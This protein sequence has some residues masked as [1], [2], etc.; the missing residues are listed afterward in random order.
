MT[1][2]LYPNLP[3]FM[4]DDEEAIL[5]GYKVALSKG[6]IN[7]TIACGDSNKALDMLHQ[8]PASLV[9]LDLTMPYVSGEELL[10]KI[11]S[12]YPGI[13]VIIVTGNDDINTAIKCIKAGASD[14][15]TKPVSRERLLRTVQQTL[16]IRELQIENEA[17]RK[18]IL[19]EELINTEA[20]SKIITANHTMISIIR[21]IA[22][23][24]ATPYPVLL[25]GETGVGKEVIAQAIHKA[26]ARTG[27]FVPVNI[28]GLDDN[29]LADTL[30]GH[31][32]GAF[33][34]AETARAG[35]IEE[36]QGGTLFL[37]E[38]GD[39]SITSQV[40]LLRL[41]QEHEY[42]PLGEDRPRKSDARIIVATNADLTELQETGKFRPDL[43]FRLH[44]HH[45]HIPPL[46][47]RLDD[48]PI[49][50]DHFLTVSADT[51]GKK[52]PTPPPEL[53]AL[54]ATYHFPGNVRELASMITDAVSRHKSKMLSMETFNSYIAPRRTKL[55]SGKA[56]E[57]NNSPES[58]NGLI[59]GQTLPPLK[60]AKR[61]FIEEAIKRSNGNMTL[62]AK[63]L[64]TTRQA[65]SW[66][67]KKDK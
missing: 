3:I 31:K 18:E 58:R 38:I 26:S 20:F 48:L 46:R 1:N 41:L 14:Y 21:Y 17:L 40:K 52:K 66:H 25:S 44:T 43:F 6:G 50:V 67:T 56:T 42:L 15:L 39:L 16:S 19:A 13:P 55:S 11:T 28:A 34:S 59:F 36:A 51:L 65:L 61:L 23:I 47:E 57:H 32:R 64:G 33:T 12:L 4:V 45:I 2:N 10:E 5:L 7:N 63:L 30:F 24:A 35:M 49:L 9:L 8:H 27:R 29:I 54:L 22:A 60:D 62:A 53:F 37:D